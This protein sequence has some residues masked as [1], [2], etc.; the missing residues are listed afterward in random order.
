MQIR[1]L[2]AAALYSA[3]ALP[4]AAQKAEASAPPAAEPPETIVDRPDYPVEPERDI[5]TPIGSEY[6]WVTNADYPPAAWRNGDV[7]AVEYE[8]DVDR[9]G[10]V[11][12]CRITQ[13][14]ATAILDA[15][16]CRLLRERAQFAPA[17][18]ADGKPIAAVFSSFVNW[19][20]RESEFAGGSFSIK[21][22]FTIDE[23]GNTSNCRVIERTGAIPQDM[24]RSFERSPCPGSRNDAP[25]RDAEGK[26]VARDIILTVAVEAAPAAPASAEEATPG[27]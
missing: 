20:R 11:T 17:K 5:P 15:E 6:S 8:L 22:G 10:A 26:P 19:Q 13:S 23:R 1:P 16:T 3:I 24:M 14:D 7:G 12:G 2:L 27:D 25:A 21:V 9:T 18:D 4:A